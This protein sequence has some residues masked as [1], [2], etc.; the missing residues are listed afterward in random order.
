LAGGV[1]PVAPLDPSHPV[2]EVLGASA[3]LPQ[4]CTLLTSSL[5]L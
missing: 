4:V 1:A 2:A 3:A 5:L